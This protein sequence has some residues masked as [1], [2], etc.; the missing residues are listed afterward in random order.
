MKMVV[1]LMALCACAVE[2]ADE[3]TDQVQSELDGK[4]LLDYKVGVWDCAASY[5]PS[6]EARTLLHTASGVYTIVK[7]G[8]GQLHGS[9]RETPNAFASGDFDDTWVITGEPAGPK[10]ASFGATYNA[11][12]GANATGPQGA[13]PTAS[14]VTTGF[15]QPGANSSIL[16]FEQFQGHLAFFEGGEPAGFLGS[17]LGLAGPTRFSRQWSVETPSGS[18]SFSPFFRLSCFKRN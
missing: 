13:T 1:V 3:L 4:Q 8:A 9:Y 11:T 2:R 5:T 7:T 10:D 14:L 12:F 6:M 18:N 17:D 16:G 15:V